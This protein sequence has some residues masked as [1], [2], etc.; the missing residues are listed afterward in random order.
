MSKGWSLYVIAL[1]VITLI[2]CIWLLAANRKAK[3]QDGEPGQPMGH[4]WDGLQDL[5]NPLPAWWT[6]LFVIT[7]VFSIV[8][9][10]LF[11]GLGHFSG[12]LSWSQVG[13]Y[14]EQV[15]AAEAK[16]GPI[17]A[18]FYGTPI[19][20][21]AGDPEA[22]EIGSRLFANHC[23]QCHGSDAQGGPGYP[24]LT[25]GDWLYGGAP[26]AVV[27]TITHGRVGNMPPMGLVVGDEGVD[28]LAQYVLSLSGRPHDEAKAAGA[29]A[30]YAQVCAV[31]HGPD[32]KGIQAVG[33]PNLTDDIWLHGGRVEDIE[34]QI[35]SGRINQMPAHVD[36]LSPEKIHILA[37]YVLSLNR[38]SSGTF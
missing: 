28:R 9:L 32:G 36:L 7:I 4:V 10:A 27:Q 23:A 14:E 12:L 20:Q 6:W 17:F 3:V 8:Y 16:Y 13:Q 24:N 31:C 11:P 5:N 35:R 30:Q 29:A 38:G 26:E 25:D 15:S 22:T 18:A 2:G 33:G 1:T 19:P 21:L 37:A 34:Y